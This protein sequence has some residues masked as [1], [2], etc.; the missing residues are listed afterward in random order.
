MFRWTTD[1]DVSC[2]DFFVDHLRIRLSSRNPALAW[3]ALHN[4]VSC[5]C[6]FFERIDRLYGHETAT[7]IFTGNVEGSTEDDDGC[8][9]TDQDG[10]KAVLHSVY[11]TGKGV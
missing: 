5:G 7:R 11:E 3:V 8:N 9:K 6:A 2:T 4:G 1:I 10:R